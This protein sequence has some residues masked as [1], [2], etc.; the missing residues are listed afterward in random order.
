MKVTK[1]MFIEVQDWDKLV[2][3]TYGKPYSFQQQYG[4]QERGIFEITIP[5]NDTLDHEMNDEI[6]EIINGEEKGVKFEVWLKK[7]PKKNSQKWENWRIDTFWH[8]N[9]Y[10]DVQTVANDLHSKGLIEAGDYV[11]NINW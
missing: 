6:P 11:I 5:S 3:E 8:R 1:K 9:F 2:K 7:N 10:P 4:C